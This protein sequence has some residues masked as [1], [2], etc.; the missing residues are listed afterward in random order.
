MTTESLR[1]PGRFLTLAAPYDRLTS[2]LGAMIGS[3]FGV[4]LDTVL[5]GAD[6]VFDTE[7]KH[8]LLKTSAQEWAA[9]DK[10]YWNAATKLVDNVST[11][12]PF[13]GYATA[14]AA[15]PSASGYVKLAPGSSLLEGVQAAETAA[16]AAAGACAGGATPSAAQVDT[17]IATAV[18]P[19]VITINSLITKLEI[20]GILTPN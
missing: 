15:N 5:S 18:A 3:I 1:A 11:V 17:A 7:G 16:A 8:Y 13:I 14:A 2:G 9:G 12:G 20:A 6:G 19:L 10:L 4:S